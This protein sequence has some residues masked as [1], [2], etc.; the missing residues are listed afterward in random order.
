MLIVGTN[1]ND[2]LTGTAGDDTLQGLGGADVLTGGSGADRT[3]G[4]SGNDVHEV[5]NALDV[6]IELAGEGYDTVKSSV[7][8]TL[9]PDVEQLILTG[10][11]SIN[12]AGNAADN[13]LTGNSG[14]NLLN[15]LA[16]ADFM[17]GGDGNDTYI[18]DNSGD[19]VAE[20]TDGGIDTIQSSVQFTLGA[21]VER[22]TLTGSAN[23]NGAGNALDNVLRGN[24]G[25]NLL[26]GLGGADV[27]QGGSG[28]DTY[29]VENL[30]DRAIESS[31][32][33]GIDTVQSSVS[34]TIGGNV[35]R[36]YLTG[37][38]NL[39]GAGNSLDN[40]IKGNSG[41]N[42]LNGMTGADLM[43][44][45][46]GDD[47]YIVDDIG[48]KP[49]ESSSAGGVDTVQSSVSF[50]IGLNIER[51]VLTGTANINGAGNGLDNTLLGNSGDNLLNGLLG[52][53]TMKGG[54]GDDTYIVDEAGDLTAESSAAGGVDTVQSAVSYTIGG[55]I[56]RLIL[57]GSGDTDGAGN[58]LDNLIVGNGGS[59]LL[60][61]NAGADRLQGGGGDDTYIVDDAGDTAEESSAA[62]GSD[63]V[64]SSVNFVLGNFVEDL[65]LTGAASIDGTGNA[66]ANVIH[67]NGG[68]NLLL[69]EAG[70]DSLSGAD[71][72]DRLDGGLGA[73]LLT[74][75]A[76]ADQFH[77]TTALGGGNIDQITDFAPGV[78][79]I[80]LAGEAGEPFAALAAGNLT[81]SAFRN[82]AVALDANDFLLYDS[83]TGALFY[84]VDGSGAGA[85]VRFATLQTGLSL[86]AAS[87]TVSGGAN[88]APVIAS[89]SAA[90]VAENSAA[91]TI[92]YQTV[93]TD[94]DGDRI[95]YSLT[96]ADASLFAIDQSG[97]VQLVSPVD[98]ETRK[99]YDI[100]VNA[101]DSSGATS[102]RA[103]T[104]SVT[105]VNE[106]AG[107]TPTIAETAAAND[108]VGQAQAIDRGALAPSD[109]PNLFDDSLPSI[110]IQ[111]AVS[112]PTPNA[113]IDFYSISLQKGEKLVLDVDA[114]GGDLDAFIRVYN[115]SGQEIATVDDARVDPGSTADRPGET[116]DSFF[117]F[118]APSDGLFYF[119]IESWGDGSDEGPGT[120]ET[121]GSYR[122]NVSIGPVGT[123]AQFL[124]EDIDALIESDGWA[125]P[126]PNLPGTNLTY[127]FPNSPSD[128]PAG[129]T[130]T[131]N[132]FE[133]FNPIQRSATTQILQQIATVADLSFTQLLDNQESGATLR[134]AMSDE[135]DVAYA[136]LPGSGLGGTAWFRNS[137]IDGRG[138]PSFD[139]PV[140]GGYAWMSIIHE[141]G[142]ALGLKHGHEAPAVS[143]D[144]DS[145]EY[146]VMTYRSYVGQDVNGYSNETWGFPTTL[147]ALDIAALQRLY[148][149][150]F[151]F[152]SGDSV[153]TWSTTTGQSFVN[154][155][156][157]LTPGNN[158]VFM[159]VWDGE[160]TDTYDLSNYSNS[161]TIDLR[162]GEWTTTSPVQIANLGFNNDARGN[163]L[164]AFLY[165][166]DPRSLIENAVGGAGNDILIANAAANDLVGGGGTDRF[167][168][169]SVSDGS[170][171]AVDHVTGFQSLSDKI[172]LSFLDSDPSTSNVDHFHSIGSGAFSG[173]AGELRQQVISGSMN[174]FGDADGDRVA[175]FHIVLDNVTSLAA[176][177]IIFF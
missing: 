15:G 82:G 50:T 9:R 157:G 2:H 78:D 106:G 139:S 96:G 138:T 112:T 129:T 55:N 115:S 162:P 20:T 33:G 71:G 57:T 118:R 92:V 172:D 144:R 80:V 161:V 48:D 88:A 156:G 177:D 113:D 110:A 21:N 126:N 4:G 165:N 12:G 67:G 171:T 45:G 51:L 131:Q 158:R 116:L 109:N 174:L 23:I 152:N 159:T 1:G 38:A 79:R 74:G 31:A 163:V 8:Y 119:S 141:T 34:F 136:Y 46:A 102:S 164:N 173:V 75:G 124:D 87:F 117:T 122:L 128:Y 40:V 120:G 44:G 32:T 111:G 101:F 154:G 85:A 89:G 58:S 140:P 149:P 47:I 19:R 125:D 151:N 155:V 28:N 176:S 35:E 65:V 56:E 166:D 11:A 5:D 7:T 66:L 42:L 142:H 68:S 77:F 97:V 99:S 130:E 53:D 3:E 17:R 168:W 103:V 147:M 145:V 76:G 107:P 83:S 94:A 146:T 123:A 104:V 169:M 26:N 70:S 167:R 86:S 60:N 39:N 36:L 6:V 91:G 133:T 10:T 43:Q 22:L 29:I 63:T 14:A 95:V 13:D 41:N 160:G 150:N 114:T 52:A 137:P 132:N 127:A 100:T 49:I 134:Y 27:M 24:S 170:D 54:D 69:G 148:G 37:S 135:P 73:D 30:G 61:G 84:D 59:N 90:S 105:D 98:F 72:N 143:F 121:T 62:G 64:Q 93:A 16:G 18:V 153:Y 175:D 108:S 25:N 81:V